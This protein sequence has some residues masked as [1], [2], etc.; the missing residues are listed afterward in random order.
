M[1]RRLIVAL[2]LCLATPAAAAPCGGDFGDFLAAMKAE[3][4]AAGSDPAQVDRFFAKVAARPE[5]C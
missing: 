4:I 2:S 1:L 3:A 5:V